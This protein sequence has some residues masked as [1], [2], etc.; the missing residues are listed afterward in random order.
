MEWG[1]LFLGVGMGISNLVT[2]QGEV[3][4]GVAVCICAGKCMMGIANLQVLTNRLQDLD[5]PA[6]LSSFYCAAV[7]CQLRP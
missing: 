2:K 7:L 6:H 5:P 1:R 4:T 3:R